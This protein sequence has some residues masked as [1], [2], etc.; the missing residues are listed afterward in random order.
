M[1]TQLYKV[2][3]LV[4]V[5]SFDESIMMYCKWIETFDATTSYYHKKMHASHIVVEEW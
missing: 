5:L 1:S 2:V 3:P 4:N